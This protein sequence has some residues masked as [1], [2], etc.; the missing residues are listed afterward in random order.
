MILNQ[1]PISTSSSFNLEVKCLLFTLVIVFLINTPMRYVK[2]D[3][4]SDFAVQLKTLEETLILKRNL[5]ASFLAIGDSQVAEQYFDSKSAFL[6]LS[7]QLLSAQSLIKSMEIVSKNPPSGYRY[8]KW[9]NAYNSYYA[10]SLNRQQTQL[11]IA[12][13]W[14]VFTEF[15][16]IYRDQRHI[17]YLV[18]EI[19]LKEFSDIGRDSMLLVNDVGTVYSSSRVGIESM[20]N[21]GDTFPKVWQDLQRSSRFAG[22]L[23]Y[24]D[25]SF[26][27]RKLDLIDDSKTYLVK[28]VDN[29]ELVPP[30]F[31]LILI[32]G[33]IT[34]G[35]SLYLYRIRKDKLELSKISFTDELSGL[36]N[37]HYLKKVSRQLT[38]DGRY[39]LCILDID[40]FKSVNDKYGHDIGDQVIKR[41]ASVIKSRIRLTDYAFRFGGEEFVVVI[42]TDSTEQ[43]VRIFDRIREDVARFV[44]APKVTISGGV[45]PVIES[46][47]DAIK[48]A[49]R[50]LY[51]AKEGG[52]N[53][54]LSEA[55]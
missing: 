12:P 20:S 3:K 30:Y 39:Y 22:L 32:F 10:S 53:T 50:L 46:V 5:A 13:Q 37:R 26:I 11:L 51:M 34:A 25:F 17:G 54:I 29:H 14:G 2:S 44:Q 55:A 35:V 42:K 33:S 52:R 15:K 28:V 27:Y 4:E 18:L 7:K 9:I 24:D 6:D 49:D 36:H 48:Q 41:V 40:H 31:Y 38:P 47:D 23:E 16:A 19:H 43:A 8:S 1:T 21:L 45:W